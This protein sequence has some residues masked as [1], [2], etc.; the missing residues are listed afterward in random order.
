MQLRFPL[1]PGYF[2]KFDLLPDEAQEHRMLASDIIRETKRDLD[3]Y[4]RNGRNVIDSKTWKLAKSKDQLHCYRR[5]G[6]EGSAHQLGLYSDS[7]SSRSDLFARSRQSMSSHSH[8]GPTDMDQLSF[9]TRSTKDGEPTRRSMQPSV[10]GYGVVSGNVD[11]LIYGLYQSSAD[12]MKTLAAYLGDNSLI[13]CAVLKTIRQT[14]S[15]YLGLKWKLSRTVGGNRDC[16]YMEYVGLS[17]DGDGQ[18]FGYHVMESVPVHNCP[19]FEDNS[20]VRAHVSFCFIF[21]PGK[22]ADQ[23]EVFMQG[24]YDS[25][26][27]A[28]TAGGV[29]DYR[30]TMDMLFNLPSTLVGAEAKKVSA[31][32]VKQS[33]AHM[34]ASTVDQSSHHCFIC[35]TKSKLLSLHSN[36]QTCGAVMCGKCRIRVVTFSRRG[37]IKVSCCKLCMVMVRDQSPFAGEEL[38][39]QQSASSKKLFDEQS[40]SSSRGSINA[41]PDMINS[42]ISTMSLSD[43]EYAMSYHSWQSSSVS[44]MPSDCSD[45]FDGSSSTFSSSILSMERKM[46]ALLESQPPLHAP[47][48]YQSEQQRQYEQQ[49]LQMQQFLIRQRM[50]QNAEAGYST[51]PGHCQQP[52]TREG[53]YNQMLELRVQ[54]E[55]AYDLTNQNG[56]MINPPR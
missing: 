33:S 29:G 17:E 44:S 37:K 38:E 53:L 30:S 22:L 7:G 10:I 31:M 23:V 25:S 43:S 6:T 50:K 46:P 56:S 8:S 32:V 35:R 12:E 20:I 28:L 4:V 14:R 41:K 51:M 26:A 3:H 45:S 47:V 36:C 1:P 49:Q 16:C 54:A 55:R 9:S 42:S 21:R 52:T 39:L 24:A 19:H 13:D 2:A 34:S 40:R 18:H 11:D 48:S 15:S 27:D 5:R